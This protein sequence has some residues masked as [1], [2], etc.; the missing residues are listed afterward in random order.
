[1]DSRLVMLEGLPGTGK[2]TNS[3][4]LTIQLKR[5]G[6]K[7][8][9]FHEVAR[10]HPTSFF[11]EACFTR[12]EHETF[13]KKYPEAGAILK[14]ITVF[15]KATTGINLMEVEWNYLG[16]IG[17]SAFQELKKY[18]AWNFL[19]NKYVEAALDK[20]A[21]FAET[22]S[23]EK[24]S[25]YIVDSSIFQ[26]QTWAFLLKNGHYKD[27]ERFVL[28]L[29]DIVKPL[30]PSLI[31]FYRK[32]VEA[33]IAYLEKERGT[34]YLEY[35][36]ERDKL[37]PYYQ[38]KPVNVE[39]HRQFLRD[40]AWMAQSLFEAAPCKKAAYEITEADWPRHEKEMLAFLGVEYMPD[41]K[42]FP[43]D[44]VYRNETINAEIVV[45]GLA[46]TDPEG[47]KRKLIPISENEFYMECLPTVLR[48][49]TP[50]RIVMSGEQISARWTTTGTA[51]DKT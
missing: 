47:K 15:R 48:F 31:Y 37:Q 18:D 42:G 11:S 21:Y 45:E 29:L 28:R 16:T 5:K 25:V 30:N 51:F 10:P 49:E 19:L 36:W 38:D 26:F 40:Y 32:N 12:E 33:T 50:G 17:D 8:K 46:V 13:L 24:D 2:S 7:V 1:M 4:L 23:I 34:A 35:I 9:W 43:H 41:P 6:N 3:Y 39:A 20:W 14:P 27:L 22:A 44:G